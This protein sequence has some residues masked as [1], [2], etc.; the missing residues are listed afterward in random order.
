MLEED[1]LRSKWKEQRDE[2]K[3]P[4]VFRNWKCSKRYM[5]YC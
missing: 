4:E 1:I 3:I 5:H 2:G